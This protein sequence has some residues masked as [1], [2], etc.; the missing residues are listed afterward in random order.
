MSGPRVQGVS[1][2]VRVVMLADASVVAPCL[3]VATTSGLRP[4]QLETW[5]EY[6]GS[7]V[8]VP[9]VTT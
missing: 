7:W 6:T 9:V 3:V 2:R 4:A 5:D 8:R 1:Q